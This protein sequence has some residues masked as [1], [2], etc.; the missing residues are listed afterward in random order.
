VTHKLAD[1]ILLTICGVI[2]GQDTWEGICDFG[3][4][5]LRFL[6]SYGDFIHGIPSADTIA[7]VMGMISPIALKDAFIKWMKDCHELTAGEVIAIDGKAV[8][9]FYNKSKD[10]Q[11]IQIVNAFATADGAF[12]AQSKVNEK[13]NE[14]T[15]SQNYWNCPILLGVR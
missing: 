6:K 2:S 15:R 14:I 3:K 4:F 11:A 8:K 12:L 5:R 1:I 7:R 13:T 10:Q 9:G